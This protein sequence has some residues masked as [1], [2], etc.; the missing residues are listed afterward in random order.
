VREII[1]SRTLAHADANEAEPDVDPVAPRQPE[2]V[3]R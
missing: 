1:T 3:E 2:R